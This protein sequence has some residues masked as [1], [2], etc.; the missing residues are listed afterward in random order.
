MTSV[1][2]TTMASEHQERDPE[3]IVVAR[4]PLATY[5]LQ[6]NASFTF[7][8]ATRLVS[9][10]RALGIS[11]CYCSPYFKA[12]PGSTHGYDV[13]D[14]NALNPELGT[15]EDY[16]SFVQA[17]QR[18]GMGHLLDLVPNHMGIATSSNAWW[19]DVLE[20]GPSSFYAACFDIDWTPIK[21]ELANKVLL[22]ILGNQYGSVLEN[23]E[24]ILSYEEGAFILTYGDFHLPIAPRPSAVVLLHRLGD[25]EHSLGPDH[26]QLLEFRSI[27]TALSHLPLRTETDPAKVIERHREKEIIKKRLA[28]VMA[29]TPEILTFVLDNVR[30]FN[31]TKAEPRSFDFLDGLLADQAYRLA[32][33]RTAAEEINYRRFFDVNSLAAVHTED[34]LVFAATHQLVLRLCGARKV[35]GLRIDHI[36]GLYDPAQ[37]LRRLQ[38]A[39]LLALRSGTYPEVPAPLARVDQVIAQLQAN[40]EP[41]SAELPCYI[42]VEKILNSDESLPQSWPIHGTTGY[43]FLADL[44]GIFV[45]A[46]TEKLLTD[47]YQRFTRSRH[48]FADLVY[49]NKKLIMQVALSSEINVLGHNLNRLSEHNRH[50]RDFTLNSLTHAL[51]EIIACFPVYRTYVNGTEGSERDHAIVEQAV[52]YAKRKNPARDV[53]I[54]NYVR[55]VLLLRFPPGATEADRQ[56]QRAFV[57]K[58]QQCTGPVMAKGV[59]D[60]AFYLYNRLVS[61]NEVGS[62]PDRFGT[63]LAAFHT[64]CGERLQQWPHALLATTTHDTKRSEDVRARIN[65]LSEVP[66]E[67]RT[68]V[69]RWSRQYKKR[70]V[71]LAGQLAPDRNDEY[72]FYQ[73]V[74]GVWP[75][76][77]MT[78]DDYAVFK[79]RIQ[80]YMRKA[81]KEAKVNTS[82]INP[83]EAY[84]DALYEFVGR[85]LDNFLFH[86]D[87]HRFRTKIARYGMYNSLSQT[88]LKLTVPGVP[89]LY[90]GTELWD[91]SLVDPDNRRPVDYDQRRQMLDALQGKLGA[92]VNNY[93]T[94]VQEL[95]ETWTDGSIKLYVTLQTLTY[96]QQHPDLFCSGEYVPLE[97]IGTKQKHLCAFARRNGHQTVV[98]AVPRLLGQVIPDPAILPTGAEIWAE[99]WLVLPSDSNAHDYR[100]LFT[101]EVVTAE[102]RESRWCLAVGDVFAHFPVALLVT[103]KENHHSTAQ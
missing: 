91:F 41:P 103:E 2:S 3:E 19:T 35:T 90:Q 65:V 102:Q 80:E 82:W 86:D 45:D 69:G 101:G 38:Q 99:T 18:H 49:E 52:A 96:R 73:T 94:V 17:L 43:D 98:V 68:L 71:L 26:P 85:V 93:L 72:L 62:S 84:D 79:Q 16:D 100:N 58:F 14:H 83:N 29:T 5:R 24:L 42:V 27:I 46:D 53:S 50:A 7:A 64:R 47:I 25:L 51:R 74:L 8:D 60:T 54:F 21:V 34:P 20:N 78:A 33:W 57:M 32:H 63:S 92:A 9:Y 23:Q 95:L 81:S 88:V 6:F 22:P 36:D 59:E 48:S 1:S 87:F 37:Y 11:D 10:L 70:K 30:F 44:N 40:I 31:G 12:S 39:L 97:T 77:P 4:V 89:D 75:L 28:T 55:D 61:L 67:W 15:E 66:A 56:A 76:T 13:I